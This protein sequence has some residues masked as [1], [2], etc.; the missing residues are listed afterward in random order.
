MDAIEAGLHFAGMVGLEPRGK[1]LNLLWRLAEGRAKSQRKQS[2]ELAA[3]VWS[4]ADIDWE[5]Y[6]LHGEM[7]ETGRGGPVQLDP[8]LQAR[9]D[10][11]AERL[12][13]ENPSLPT[14]GPR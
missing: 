10:Q 3:L 6:L 13:R 2:L 14:A 7:S 4:V 12:R 8:E 5:E 11:E 1:T 9:V